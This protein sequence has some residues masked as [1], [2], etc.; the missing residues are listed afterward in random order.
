MN[1]SLKESA[2][3]QGISPA[4]ISYGMTFQLFPTLSDQA[5]QVHRC[6]IGSCST[7]QF[8]EVQY[9]VS[10]QHVKNGTKQ[11]SQTISFADLQLV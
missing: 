3:V 9:L 8:V 2:V 5:V 7:P 4:S 6:S 1:L 11:G 10:M